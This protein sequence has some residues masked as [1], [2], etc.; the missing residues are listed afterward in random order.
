[1]PMNR[2]RGLESERRLVQAVTIHKSKGLQYPLVL[3]PFI[4]DWRI[5]PVGALSHR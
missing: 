4:A 2:S 3:L 1:M 5:G